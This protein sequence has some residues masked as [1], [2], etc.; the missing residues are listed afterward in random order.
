[1]LLL[2]GVPD[3]D[4][5]DVVSRADVETAWCVFG[6]GGVVL[7][8]VVALSDLGV[9]DL[10]DDNTVTAGVQEVLTLGVSAKNDGLA[11][12]GGGNGSVD[13]LCSSNNN[14]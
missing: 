4:S 9:T 12:G 5:T 13:S 1:M 14:N 10:A 8:F 6:N 3:T 11:T 7:M 2:G